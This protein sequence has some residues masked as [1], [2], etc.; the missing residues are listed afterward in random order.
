MQKKTINRNHRILICF[1]KNTQIRISLDKLFRSAATQH[2]E[3]V[4]WHI[5][6]FLQFDTSFHMHKGK[7]NI[8]VHLPL[9]DRNKNFDLLQ[10]NNAPKQISDSVTLKLSPPGNILAKGQDGVHTTMTCKQ[11]LSIKKYGNILFSDTALTLNLL[12]NSSC[13]GTIYSRDYDN[14]KV[15]SSLTLPLEN[16]SS[17]PALLKLSKSGAH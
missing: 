1:L 13:L 4:S 15:N 6:A 12:L 9:Y 14:I 5:A 2:L 11:L 17:T 7:I 8:Y 16:T 3:P 10:F